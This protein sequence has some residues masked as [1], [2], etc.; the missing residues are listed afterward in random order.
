MRLK[1]HKSTAQVEGGAGSGGDELVERWSAQRKT[2]LVLPLL[3]G[4]SLEDVSRESQIPAHELESWKRAF[5]E[6]GTRG[7][8]SRGEPEERELTLALKKGGSGKGTVT[9]DPSGINC[10]ADCTEASAQYD[11]RTSVK[12]TFSKTFTDDPLTAQVT[13]IKALHVTELQ[14]AI[15]TLR[16]RNGLAAFSFTDPTLTAGVTQVRAVHITDLRTALNGVYDAL[17]RALP[18]YMDPTITAAQT[19]IKAAHI[20]EIRSAIRAVE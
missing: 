3:R 17:G 5:V 1:R 6:T 2:E 12:A 15:N 19:A 11:S 18:T 10:G 13:K 16:S 14:N 8:K 20:S 7:L 4:E 9:S